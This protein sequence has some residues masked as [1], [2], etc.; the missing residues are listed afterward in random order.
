M[1]ELSNVNPLNL[2]TQRYHDWCIPASVAN[3]INYLYPGCGMTQEYIFSFNV[4][5][6]KKSMCFDTIV[7]ILQDRKVESEFHLNNTY[8]ITPD[9]FNTDKK[10]Y[11]DAC[12]QNN[13]PIILSVG[14]P[15]LRGAHM[16]TPLK[17]E[18]DA[19]TIWDTA[20][21]MLAYDINTLFDKMKGCLIISKN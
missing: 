5:N 20:G 18:N 11:I 4:I 1:S 6:V 9:D 15:N 16:I 14:P 13:N 8:E 3:A 10:A 2:R 19:L 21:G 12:L 7:E 17:L